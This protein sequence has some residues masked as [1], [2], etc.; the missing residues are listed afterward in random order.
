[1]RYHVLYLS[2][3]PIDI[4]VG[5]KYKVHAHISRSLSLPTTMPTPSSELKAILLTVNFSV[6]S[7]LLTGGAFVLLFIC[8]ILT[9]CIP[10]NIHGSVYRND[11]RVL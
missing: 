1:M 8:R 5:G 6:A 3:C 2:R 4:E 10:R 7:I 11:A 9:L